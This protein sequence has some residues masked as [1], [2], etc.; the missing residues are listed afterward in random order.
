M[1]HNMNQEKKETSINAE[2]QDQLKNL[3]ELTVTLMTKVNSQNEAL[4]ETRS[5]VK[6]Q[7]EALRSTTYLVCVFCVLYVLY[8]LKSFSSF[9]H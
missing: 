2:I 3:R 8:V 6:E 9:F 1:N 5:Q 7:A 4:L